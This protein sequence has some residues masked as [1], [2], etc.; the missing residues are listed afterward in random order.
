MTVICEVLVPKEDSDE[1]VFVSNLLFANRDKVEKNVGILDI[2]TSKAVFELESLEEGFVEYLVKEGDLVEIGQTVALIH[3]SPGSIKGKVSR[4]ASIE[5]KEIDSVKDI[6]VTKDAQELIEKN[7]LDVSV[8]DSSFVRKQD[9]ENL[10]NEQSA[11]SLN[12][13]SGKAYTVK[14]LKR[15]KI[16]E[17]ETLSDV[18][19]HGLVSTIF[20]NFSSRKLEQEDNLFSSSTSS[21]LPLIT[22][23]VASLLKEFP[24]FNAY[25]FENEIREYSSVNVGIAIDVDSGLKVFSIPEA[26]TL[27]LEEINNLISEGVYKYLRKELSPKDLSNS[28]FTI[29]DLSQYG[30]ESFVPLI[31]K[32]QSSIL[33]I[34]SIDPD[35]KRFNVSL[36]FDHRVTEGKQASIFLGRLKELFEETE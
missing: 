7:N 28:T 32:N 16:I 18:Q 19:N 6:K 35:L 3:D 12:E 30:V 8:F 11:S 1:E 23:N 27:T 10:L 13:P 21:F 2:E 36:S 15:S 25:F 33:G 31:N 34:S 24:S 9:V 20:M 22:S 4:K 29:T 14:V 26:N 17:I 5:N